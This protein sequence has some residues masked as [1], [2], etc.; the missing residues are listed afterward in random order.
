M[1]SAGRRRPKWSLSVPAGE[2][3]ITPTSGGGLRAR[4][5]AF[6]VFLAILPIAYAAFVVALLLGTVTFDPDSLL[7]PLEVPELR[8]AAYLSL[9]TSL[10][11]V[12]AS[13]VVAIP[14]GYVLSRLR[15][16]GRSLIDVIVDLPIVLPPLVVGICLLIFFRSQFGIWIEEDLL[17]RIHNRLY[18]WFGIRVPMHYRQFTYGVPGIVLAQFTVSCAFAVRTM[19]AG[20]DASPSR[21]GDVARTLGASR[22]RAFWTVEL[23]MVRG[24]ILAAAILAWSRALGEFGPILFFVGATP[25]RTLVLSTAIFLEMSVGNLELALALSAW[26]IGIAAVTLL[27]LRLPGGL[28][29]L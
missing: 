27:G 28:L 18:D 8:R 12:F 11:A 21:P 22:M 24:S 3:A 6:L 1:D 14:A 29:N 13:L 25:N 2:R 17:V 16:P 5:T 23:P 20:F 26:L 15:F 10:G 9:A 4:N 7:D 19:K